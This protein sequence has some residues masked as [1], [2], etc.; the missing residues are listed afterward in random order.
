MAQLLIGTS[1]WN[2]DR[3]KDAF[4][5]GLPQREWLRYC[6]TCFTSLEINATFYRLQETETLARWR[7]ET[8]ERF[9]FAVKA[10]RY[11]THY[12]RLSEPEESIDLE[13]ER[14]TA[15]DAKLGAVLWQF[16]Q[17]FQRHDAR[18][19]RFL[20][21]LR[22][23]WPA[24]HVL[25]FRHASWFSPEIARRLAAHGVAACI[26]DAADWPMW[27]SEPAP[28]TTDF[29][30]VRLHGHT[31]T[32]HSGYAKRSL[33]RWA[34]KARTWL[35]QG[36]DVHVYFDNTDAGAAPYDAM[37]LRALVSGVRVHA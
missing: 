16:P 9:M 23:R 8:P 31:H 13:R 32:Y 15:L 3:W 33:E 22:Q 1:G 5:G 18:L 20:E 11:L 29:V 10:N 7:D 19:D 6:S 34:H 17:N 12:R 27:E 25:E 36:R 4:Y 26:S 14:A 24:R 35:A 30:Y 37:T 28:A 2:Y 21:A